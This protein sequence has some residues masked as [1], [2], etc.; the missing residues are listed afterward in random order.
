MSISGQ[1]GGQT[2]RLKLGDL[3]KGTYTITYDSVLNPNVSVG[4]KEW[5]NRLDG[6]KNKA[7]LDQD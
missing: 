3:S 4:D 2:A 6:S 5:I 7:L 1:T